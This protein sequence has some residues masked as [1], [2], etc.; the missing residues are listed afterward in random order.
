MLSY[1][2]PVTRRES[3]RPV[4]MIPNMSSSLNVSFP[5]SRKFTTLRKHG[6]AVPA[7]ILASIARKSPWVVCNS[8]LAPLAGWPDSA[9]VRF[10]RIAAWF[11]RSPPMPA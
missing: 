9:A 11:K 5:V 6:K 4:P 3:R 1:N 7:G 10:D 8:A 2:N